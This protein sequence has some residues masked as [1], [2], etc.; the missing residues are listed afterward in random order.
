MGQTEKQFIADLVERAFELD[1]SRQQEIA[2]AIARGGEK[3]TTECPYFT[4]ENGKVCHK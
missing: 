4:D 2:K 1:H 3:D